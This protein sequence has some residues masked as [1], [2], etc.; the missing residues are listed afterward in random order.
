MIIMALKAALEQQRFE[1]DQTLLFEENEHI[2]D[3]NASK[4]YLRERR[5]SMMRADPMRTVDAADA[6]RS[7]ANHVCTWLGKEGLLSILENINPM[8]ATEVSRLLS[9]QLSETEANEAIE[10]MEK[11]R[12]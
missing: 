6:F 3:R 8:Y 7:A 11:T 4:D 5:L 2:K 10:R 12:I 1:R 9:S